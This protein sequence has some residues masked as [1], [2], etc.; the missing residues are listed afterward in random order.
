M[1]FRKT[2][3]LLFTLTSLATFASAQDPGQGPP[4]QRGGGGGQRMIEDLANR[5]ELDANQREQFDKIMADA[6]AQAAEAA[7]AEGQDGGGGGRRGGGGPQMMQ[8]VFEKLTP[9]LRADQVEKLNQFRSEM[10]RGRNPM[11]RLDQL[12]GQLELTPEQTQQFDEMTA[13][14]RE[15][16]QQSQNSDEARQLRDAMREA[17]QSGDQAKIDELRGKMRESMGNMNQLMETF[18]EDLNKTLT[19]EQQKKLADY[20]AQNRMGGNFGRVD[21]KQVIEIAMRLDLSSEQRAAVSEVEQQYADQ[22]KD[23]GSNQRAAGQ[24]SQKLI[25]DINKMLSDDQKKQFDTMLQRVGGRNGNQ[26]QRGQGRRGQGQNA[27]GA[28]AEAP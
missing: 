6:R 17:Q 27:G 9:I 10:G 2:L 18:Y 16:F 22:I 3:G 13:K 20:R 28:P 14:L 8:Q 1:S 23:S 24:L 11:Q 5:L 15:Q 26:P 12:K 19:P 21:P 4:P 25:D 7:P